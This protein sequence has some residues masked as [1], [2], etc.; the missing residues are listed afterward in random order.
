MRWRRATTCLVLLAL[1]LGL[2][3]APRSL[4][5]DSPVETAKEAAAPGC[6]DGIGFTYT[7]A[8]RQEASDDND[9]WEFLEPH[10]ACA[11]FD[12]PSLSA[13]CTGPV[14]LSS[15]EAEAVWVVCLVVAYTDGG[16]DAI[17]LASDTFKLY[18]DDTPFAANSE[19]SALAPAPYDIAPPGTRIVAGDSGGGLVAFGIPTDMADDAERDMLLVWAGN[20]PDLPGNGTRDPLVIIVAD[21]EPN[22]LT[23]LTE[24]GVDITSG[25]TPETGGAATE[26]AL[27][28]GEGGTVA[29][30]GQAD[31]ISDPFTLPA[32]L[33]IVEANYAG[34]GNFQVWARTEA[35]GDTLVINEIGS[36]SG[37]GALRLRA[38][39][40]LII[41]VTGAGPW[42]V[43]IRPAF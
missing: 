19:V 14:T 5:Q 23:L 40:R 29:L 41:D 7:D 10:I 36:Y 6:Y 31:A 35:D 32:G 39:A 25:A 37:E 4:A 16:G 22:V 1:A 43:S 38:D 17:D 28:V 15:V 9:L 21:R 8:E 26:E 20:G 13:Q 30:T 33:Y 24:H 18:S 11:G 34:E 42:E 12:Q 3:S 2:P 27:T